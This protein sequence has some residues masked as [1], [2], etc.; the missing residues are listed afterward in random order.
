VG[1]TAPSTIPG[2]PLLEMKS[3]AKHFDGIRA[4][5]DVN[6]SVGRGEVHALVG[7]NGAG[8]STLI[9]ILSGFYT[10]DSGT[11]FIDGKEILLR[12]PAESWAA[13]ISV[14]Y[15]DF[16]LAPNLSVAENLLLGRE[17]TRAGLLRR[18]AN[19]RRAEE[20]LQAADMH[21][22]TRRLV[23]EL[24]IAQRQLVAIARA[25]SYSARLLVMDEPTSALS[26]EDSEHLLRLIAQVRRDGTSVIYISHKME[27]VFAVADVITVLRDGQCVGTRRTRDTTRAEIV[28]L[29]V[30][31][32][33][34]SFFTKQ[35]RVRDEMLLEVEGISVPGVFSDVSFRLR[36]GEILGIYGLKGSGRSEIAASIFGLQPVSGGR[37]LVEGR[38]LAK[39]SARRAIK[40]GI[41]MIPEDRALLGLF[42]NMNVREN[43]SIALLDRCSS[44]G[45]L[46]KGQERSTVL[47][48]ARRM[49]IR[50]SGPEQMIST[51][52]GGNQQKAILARW[53]AREP[54]LLI[55][56]EPTV[57]I[58]VGAKAEIY[59]L[60]DELAQGGMGLLLISSELPEVIGMSDRILVVNA[61]RIVGEFSR[62]EATEEKIINCI[63]AIPSEKE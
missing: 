18:S 2:A 20:Y 48:Y 47:D 29:M 63:H 30:G 23:G 59:R 61:G 14:I 45:F 22:D 46:R 49:S 44:M 27:E 15:Q 5:E 43:V 42:P 55:L 57:G 17:S 36:H 21:I 4:L 33:L 60:M 7:E 26:V 52:S 3:I 11:V 19:T 16:D 28:S 39:G 9:K 1:L 62:A 8:K 58:D 13:G 10:R 38:T 34:E 53:L 24:T 25:L 35:D 54:I 56:D 12:S 41:G 37:I 31:R 40:A 32:E 50:M 51:L 6:L